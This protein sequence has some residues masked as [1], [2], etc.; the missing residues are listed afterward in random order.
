MSKIITL[1]TGNTSWW[2]NIKYRREAATDLKKY[3]KQGFKILK[4]KTYCLDGPNSLV[5]SDYQ[6]FKL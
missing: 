3:R 1:K 2:K 5:Y 4:I 6:L